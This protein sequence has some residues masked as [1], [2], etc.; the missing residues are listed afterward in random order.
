MADKISFYGLSGSGKSCYIFAMSQALSQ[1]IPFNDGELLTVITPQPRQMLRL[2]KA[3]DKMVNG[4][5]P[6]GNVESVNYNFNVRKALDLLMTLDIT[7]FRGGLLDSTDEDDEE[8]Q[9]MLFDSYNDSSVLLFFIGADR[10]K[11][12]MSGD[13]DARFN[14]QFFN[15][16][17]E[18]YLDNAETNKKTPVMVVLTKSDM[19]TETEKK[20]AI[21][22]LK[23]QMRVLFGVGTGITA[24][25][26][27]VTLGSNLSNEGGELEG[28]LNIKPTAGNLNIPIL[29]S[30]F[31]VMAKKIEAT[32]GAID[33]SESD[34]SSSQKALSHELSR[35]AFSRFFVNNES[36]IRNKI[37]SNKSLIEQNKKDLL[38]IYWN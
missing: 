21:A 7:D 24:G 12:A 34:L 30:L 31:H 22:F 27:A 4:H 18:R 17:Y 2:Y 5:W 13:F 3:Y 15:S 28:Q 11:A 6:E 32:I 23:D 10:T 8:E 19:L 37:N 9:K 29:F 26:T 35:N 33:V 14:I 38:R 25:I 1:G 36:T 16:L 20:S